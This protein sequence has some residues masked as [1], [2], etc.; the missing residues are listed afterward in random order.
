MSAKVIWVEN[1]SFKYEISKHTGAAYTEINEADKIAARPI[2]EHLL[3]EFRQSVVEQVKD[4][5][6]HEGVMQGED[7]ILEIGAE[8][9]NVGIFGSSPSGRSLTV[10]VSIRD[11]SSGK[12][13]WA[14]SIVVFGPA[15]DQDQER[16]NLFTNKL[17]AELKTAK[18][19]E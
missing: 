13:T 17:M 11:K 5:L 15:K 14:V 9:G 19:L 16:V 12:V 10:R 7:V 18:L 8:K 4:Q 2:M 6:A 1:K 3:S